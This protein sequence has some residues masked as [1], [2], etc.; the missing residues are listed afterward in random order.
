MRD[1]P[2]KVSEEQLS[3]VQVSPYHPD[4]SVNLPRHLLHITPYT[5][6]FE[7]KV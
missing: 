4:N 6:Y 1:I 7:V 5:C 2:P 3:W